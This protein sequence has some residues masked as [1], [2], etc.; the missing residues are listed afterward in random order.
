MVGGVVLVGGLHHPLWRIQRRIEIN[1]MAAVS[2]DES[3][4]VV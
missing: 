1:Q 4:G 2:G 3:A